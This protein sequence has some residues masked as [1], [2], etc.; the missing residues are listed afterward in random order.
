MLNITLYHM[1]LAQEAV[2]IGFRLN[3]VIA[4]LA[5][6]LILAVPRLLNLIVAIYLILIGLIEVF[7]LR[8]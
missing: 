8:L 4:L 7:G 3:G 5:G 1:L 2:Q 6:I